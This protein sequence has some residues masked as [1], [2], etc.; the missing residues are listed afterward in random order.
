V[1]FPEQFPAAD[2][3]GR[4]GAVAVQGQRDLQKCVATYRDLFPAG[5]FDPAL[6][7]AIAFANA[8]CAPWLPASDLRA[9]NRTALWTFALDRLVDVVATTDVQVRDIVR[10]CRAVADGGD[11]ATGDP[12]TAMLGAIRDELATA[13]AQR[14]YPVWRDELGQT[15]DSM[16]RESRWVHDGVRPTVEEYLAN[17]ANLGFSFV[18]ASHWLAT[19]AASD[20]SH[21]AELTAASHG[22]QMVIRLVND[23]ATFHRDLAT[24]DLNVLLLG[25]APAEV[26][27][28]VLE[29]T[30]R[31]RDLLGVVQSVHPLLVGYL[32]RQVEFN[33]GFHPVTDY[34]DVAAG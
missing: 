17:A 12:L 22:V 20:V 26:R 4:I 5:A 29:L 31:A 34:W 10:R 2:A 9:A 18:F 8:A 24:G 15:L 32:W 25:L 28:Q 21:L 33:T 27:R 3:C 13:P 23:L 1:P 30:A 19:T 16:A 7:S 11:P 14:L 6:S